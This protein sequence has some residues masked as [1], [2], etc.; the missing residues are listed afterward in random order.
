MASAHRQEQFDER[1]ARFLREQRARGITNGADRGIVSVKP[2]NHSSVTNLPLGYEAQHAGITCDGAGPRLILTSCQFFLTTSAS[3]KFSVG[4]AI[5]I[6]GENPLVD[7][8]D[9]IPAAPNWSGNKAS[10]NE[11]AEILNSQAYVDCDDGAEI[12]LWI[13]RYNANGSA[14]EVT[15]TNISFVGGYSL[16]TVMEA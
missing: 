16:F 3:G 14:A 4:F 7:V 5:R 9:P 1:M 15:T 2:T 13:V 12:Q 8:S 10:G 11:W 6:D